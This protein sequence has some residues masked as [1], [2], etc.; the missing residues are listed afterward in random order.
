M[1]LKVNHNR[2]MDHHAFLQFTNTLV[3]SLVPVEYL[4][5]SVDVSHIVKETLSIDDARELIRQAYLQPFQEPN[6][7][8]VICIRNIASE[9]Q[10]ALLK[11]FEEPPR[12]SIFYVLLSPTAFL[13]PTLRSRL[14]VLESELAVGN[15]DKNETFVS[16]L[17]ESQAERLSGIE[18]ATKAKDVLWIEAILLGCEHQAQTSQNKRLLQSVITARSYLGS[19]GSSAKMLLED[20]S[21]LLD[22]S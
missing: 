15:A 5:P 18:T 19:R 9:A 14:C 10:Q 3:D 22:V 13:L 7:V 11:I 16:F 4:I 2:V 6:R 1:A 21:L 8:F 17:S 20:L 12:Q